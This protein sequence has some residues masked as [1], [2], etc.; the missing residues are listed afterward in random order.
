LF[1]NV[2]VSRLILLLNCVALP[3]LTGIFIILT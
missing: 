3:A 2:N 1:A